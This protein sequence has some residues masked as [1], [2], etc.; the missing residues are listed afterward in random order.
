MIRGL[1]ILNSS[2]VGSRDIWWPDDIAAKG[3]YN[4]YRAF[5]RPENWVKQNLYPLP[6]HFWRDQTELRLVT[7]QV[8]PQDFHE[9]GQLGHYIIHLPDIP[10]QKWADPQRR[11]RALATNSNQDVAIQFNDNGTWIRPARVV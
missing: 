8:Q 3:G 10:F 7:Y 11:N 4:V 6:V 1:L 2:Y 5:D 9:D